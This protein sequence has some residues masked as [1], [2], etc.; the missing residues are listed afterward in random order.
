MPSFRGV[1]KASI[2]LGLFAAV[3]FGGGALFV[4]APP[5][6]A[7][8]PAPGAETTNPAGEPAAPIAAVRD[9]A[10][11]DDADNPRAPARAADDLDPALFGPKAAPAFAN[12]DSS[13]DAV[14]TG[15]RMGGGALQD[16]L[17]NAPLT[18]GDSVAVSV[19]AQTDISDAQAFL[20]SNG[21]SIDYSGRTWLEAYVPAGLLGAL[22]ER[23]DV[24][25]VSPIIPAAATQTTCALTDLGTVSADLA[26]QTGTWTSTCSTQYYQFTTTAT[27]AVNIGL[28]ANGPYL[29]LRS[30]AD[31]RTA[32][33]LFE[34]DGGAESDIGIHEILPAGTYTIAATTA[35]GATSGN[36]T[37][38]MGYSTVNITGADCVNDLGTASSST[39][40]TE[41]DQTWIAD[42]DSAKLGGRHAKFYTFTVSATHHWFASATVRGSE[43][44]LFLTK[45]GSGDG[46][47]YV[48]G[49]DVTDPE[50]IP[51]IGG[52]KNRERIE[53][54]LGAGD[55]TIEVA[56]DAPGTEGAF[57]L[58][59]SF[60][61]TVANSGGVGCAQN[62]GARGNGTFYA[63][64]DWNTC[65]SS[66]DD[67]LLN[68]STSARRLIT[69]ETFPYDFNQKVELS[70]R[71]STG[72][73]FPRH[74][75]APVGVNVSH[76]MVLQNGDKTIIAKGSPNRTSTGH[77]GVRVTIAN[78]PSGQ[79]ATPVN[80][81][82]RTPTP[83]PDA[84]DG[85]TEVT[86]LGTAGTTA[87]VTSTH[88]LGT[89][90]GSRNRPDAYGNLY[91]LTIADPNT[92][93]T[94][95]ADSTAVNPYIY[96]ME[97]AV[98]DDGDIIAQDDDG[99]AG[100]NAQLAGV[101]LEP[102]TYSLEV[103]SNGAR[104]TGA[105]TLTTSAAPETPAPAAA[106]AVANACSVKAHLR[107]IHG[108]LTRSGTWSGDC[109]SEEPSHADAETGARM[110][111]DYYEINLPVRSFVS[112]DA[113]AGGAN[114]R[115]YL[116]N[117]YNA[118]TGG[119]VA[120]D[121]NDGAGAN[122]DL[123]RIRQVLNA[124]RYTIEVAQPDDADLANDYD[125]TIG[126]ANVASGCSGSLGTFGPLD[127]GFARAGRGSCSYS[128][129]LSEPARAAFSSVGS[130]TVRLRAA[131]SNQNRIADY[132]TRARD[133]SETVYLPKGGYTLSASGG[134]YTVAAALSPPAGEGAPDVHNVDEWRAAGYGGEGVKIAV[135][136]EGFAGYRALIGAELPAPAGER[137]A[138]GP[139]DC[140]SAAASGSSHGA[141]VAEAVH[142]VAPDAALYLT[143][144][145]TPGEL[146]ASADWMIANDIDIANVS[147]TF[148]W[149]GAPNGDSPSENAVS[150][151]VAKA[152]RAGVLWV[153]AAGNGA[154]SSWSAAYADAD[155]DNLIEFATGDETNAVNI[156]TAGVYTFE[157]RWEDVWRASNRDMDLFLVD[158]LNNVVGKSENF[159]TGAA[160][161]RPLEAITV[162][163]QPG[164]YRLVARQV[165]GTDPAWVQ[166]RS[167]GGALPLEVAAGV[168]SVGAPAEFGN[169]AV[170]AVGAAPYYATDS[171]AP[172]SAR[173]PA[174]DGRT[175]P[176]VVGAESA[177]SAAAG[178]AP[179][180]GTSQAAANVAGLAALLKQKYPTATPMTLAAHLRDFAERRLAS[181][182][183]PATDDPDVNNEWGHGLA[184]LHAAKLDPAA[185]A[186]TRS[187][188]AYG[189]RAGWS[190]SMRSN[191]TEAVYGAPGDAGR[192]G[193]A[194]VNDNSSWGDAAIELSPA[195]ALPP[196]D[197]GYSVAM[198]G[199]GSVIA[200]GA[201]GYPGD[202]TGNVFVFARPNTGWADASSSITLEATSADANDD[203]R[204]GA[205]VSVNADG[206]RIAVGAPGDESGKGAAYVF[207][208][209]GGTW[210]ASS[211]PTAKLT[212][213]TGAADGDAFGTSVS[214][215]GDS[216][217]LIVGAPGENGGA[218]A[219]HIF[220]A[221]GSPLAW[222]TSAT[223]ALTNARGAPGDRFGFSVSASADGEEI[224]IGAPADAHGGTGAAH[225][226]I[227]GSGA[228]SDRSAPTTSLLPSDRAYGDEFGRSVSM[229]SLGTAVAVG[230]P[231]SLGGGGAVYHFARGTS[232]ST[233]PRSATALREFSGDLTGAGWSVSARD[234]GDAIVFGSP[235]RRNAEG[236]AI[237]AE[238]ISSTVSYTALWTALDLIESDAFGS[239]AA[240]SGDKSAAVV[241]APRAV[242]TGFTVANYQDAGAAYVFSGASPSGGLSTETPTKLAPGVDGQGKEFAE[243][244][245]VSGDGGIIVIG[246][247]DRLGTGAGTAYVFTKPSSGWGS[248]GAIS[249]GYARLISGGSGD[250]FGNAVAISRDG[251]LIAVGAHLYHADNYGA[252]YVFAMPSGGWGTSQLSASD[253][254]R[255]TSNRASSYSGRALAVSANG[256]TVA[257]GAPS[258]SSFAGAAYVFTRPNAG[259]G[260]NVEITD[261]ARVTV[262]EGTGAE[263]LDMMGESV[264]L[265]DDGGLLFVG[266]PDDNGNTGAV[267]VFARPNAG[268]GTS[269]IASTAS[270]TLY[271]RKIV[272]ED[273]AAGGSFGAS[274]AVSA[275]GARL[276]VGAY[277]RGVDVR[278]RVGAAYLFESPPAGWST[279]TSTSTAAYLTAPRTDEFPRAVSDMGAA[280]S[281]SEDGSAALVGAPY[282]D[283]AKGAAYIYDLNAPDLPSVSVAST[284]RAET[285][286]SGRFFNFPVS[287]SAAG[288]ERVTV[289]YRTTDA[290]SAA[291]GSGYAE[292]YGTISFAPGETRKTARVRLLSGVR[293]GETVGVALSAPTNAELGAKTATGTAPQP[294]RTPTPGGSGGSSGG[295]G[296][297]GGG[298]TGSARIGLSTTSLSFGVDLDGDVRASRTIEVWN[299]GSGRLSFTVSSS[300]RWLTASPSSEDSTG[301]N[302]RESVRVTANAEG[303]S[304]GRYRGTLTIRASGTS[305][306]EVSVRLDV[307]RSESERQPVAPPVV[308]APPPPAATPGTTPAPA[309]TPAPQVF[310]TP[311]RTVYVVVPQGATDQ[312]VEIAVASRAAADLAGAPPEGERVANAVSLDT[313]ALGGETPLEITYSQ[314]VNLRFAMPVGLGMACADGRARVYRVSADGGWQRVSHHC[315]TDET[316]AVY[317][318]VSLNRFSEYVLTI[319]QTAPPTATPTPEPTAVPTATPVPTPMPTATPEP[320][321]PPMPTATATPW[322]PTATPTR[323]PTEP[324]ATWT[325]TATP[326]P[327][328]ATPEPTATSVPPTATPPIIVAQATATAAPATPVPPAVA[329]VNPTPTAAPPPAPAPEPE[330]GGGANVALIAIIAIAVLAAIG[331]GAYFT[332]RQR[333]MLG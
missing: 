213:G 155:S 92:H 201:P 225:V 281:L 8:E 56:K 181:G 331:G 257:L 330:S 71:R 146:A 75:D 132:T 58:D 312:P 319:A 80:D 222:P 304:E 223:G 154:V 13:L 24:I 69:A 57:N 252:A 313:Y 172:Y 327:P 60:V 305:D 144:A 39:A 180:A 29:I 269:A 179:F 309:A 15:A 46:T 288:E 215:S 240:I 138:S 162:S 294:P 263:L 23:A 270:N 89:S 184:R 76:S 168:R 166:V 197:F 83:H 208:R 101:P 196:D 145:T 90:C 67:E 17:A 78:V 178:G 230:A 131:S 130:A 195:W 32:A 61:G 120:Q 198:S 234:S 173:G 18:D 316:G 48:E 7:D 328:T 105:F 326:M 221:S 87:T 254:A 81:L 19:R 253:A 176:D 28:E 284:R 79:A 148:P 187:D 299:A 321:A 193:F 163:L 255:L 4:D 129:T 66:G 135:L 280:V 183:D 68:F 143:R 307:T 114:P 86:D 22:S 160:G 211:A 298:G 239:A 10:P 333:G 97:G 233:A 159:Q 40:W 45:G 291:A 70:I 88:S 259:W 300:A 248:G 286:S 151:S 12:L 245:A 182:D 228:W 118:K 34:V 157:M 63:R 62:F 112:I 152:T 125:L 320:T 207:T 236:N 227:K 136:D 324:A 27:A 31:E 77:V 277:R 301:R 192:S 59:V 6:G 209:S 204:F 332:L 117:G 289:E 127:G 212:A 251:S 167:F 292:A 278:N 16:A 325:P 30:G 122:P 1:I 126:V 256:D 287:L 123:A 303:L 95:A 150:R 231:M 329:E 169:P 104:E 41:Y 9:S 262:T 290:G 115:L 49:F 82:P 100:I 265:S 35:S 119:Y 295:G 147:L 21:V 55:Y 5:W 249:G 206:T 54:F 177:L 322:L 137:C 235:L 244:V 226:F 317:A 110:H 190:V 191:G 124:G 229:G 243:S 161:H 272:P 242:G 271:A 156:E 128:F 51:P 74:G 37:L 153:N 273:G 220:V 26:D 38:T 214:I 261:S 200:V 20:E 47:E 185:R 158:T 174:A 237:V 94:V 73:L 175:K 102:G 217:T 268:W 93:L 314:R 267:Y 318:V 134:S 202:H 315:E 65:A 276:A 247:G 216:T 142:D 64:I 274:L 14:A 311:D 44:Q 203:D 186:F 297:T 238:S 205:S 279:E 165:T 149:D 308:V 310:T 91:E 84:C 302:N 121:A 266:A 323:Q 3:V 164:G 285:A 224:A 116:R 11:P 50:R 275:D 260:T 139:S 282:Y 246:G 296:G 25:G 96:L 106:E 293:A 141:S 283:L 36:F 52:Q 85:A 109:Q 43:T 199:D 218:G 72:V 210:A 241:G 170:V 258:D 33:P 53:W 194:Y 232:W 219:A 189:S 188:S 98:A 108:S 113:N 2:A 140:L 107:E 250:G 111:A 103:T 133:W 264:A 171:I 99:G 306:R 42:C